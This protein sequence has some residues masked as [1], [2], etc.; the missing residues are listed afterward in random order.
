MAISTTSQRWRLLT[1]AA[2]VFGALLACPAQATIRYQ[3]A[4]SRPAEHT[5]R[6]GMT[7]PGVAGSV[8]VQMAAWDGLY[9]IRDFAHHVTEMRASDPTGR[10]LPLVRLDKETWRIDGTGEVRVQYGAF[11]DD[12]GPF[13]SQL[14]AEHAFLNLAM[15][16]CYV[17]GRIA[18]DTVVRFDNLPQGWRVAAE[19]P[20]AVGADSGATAYAASNYD[21]LVDAPV[22]IG[23][24]EEDRKSVV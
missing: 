12:S 15:V 21:A 14:D 19:L 13:G 18:E 1:T 4:L 11:W 17:P 24:F 7:I 23:R 20:M 6:V 8:T 5:F 16:L 3:V 9:Q 2:V 22:E 10:T